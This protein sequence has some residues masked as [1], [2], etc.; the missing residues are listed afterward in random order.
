MLMA[1][2][3]SPDMPIDSS[4]ACAC[5]SQS[6]QV[7]SHRSQVTSHRSQ[8][9]GRRSQVTG[10][11]S[12]QVTGHKSQQVTGGWQAGRHLQAAALG[13]EVTGLREQM[14]QL[15]GTKTANTSA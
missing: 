12:Q 7:T 11:R 8:V 14:L 9:T 10:H 1:C 3:K 2:S 5:R 6:Q 4:S 13:H 15:S